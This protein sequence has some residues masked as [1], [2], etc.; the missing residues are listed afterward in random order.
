[1]REK[2]QQQQL[3]DSRRSGRREMVE[4]TTDW[5]DVYHVTDERA[6]ASPGVLQHWRRLVADGTA[7]SPPTPSLSLLP[8]PPPPTPPTLRSL[9]L[10]HL[11]RHP[12]DDPLITRIFSQLP[13]PNSLQA[14]LS[15]S[16]PPHPASLHQH[17][18]LRSKGERERKRKRVEDGSIRTNGVRSLHAPYILPCARRS[19]LFQ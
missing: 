12:L 15:L 5:L 3:G 18:T 10:F 13:A 17:T 19:A 8:P 7:A 2:G 16:P 4:P 1:M 14:P 11:L 6:G 9:L